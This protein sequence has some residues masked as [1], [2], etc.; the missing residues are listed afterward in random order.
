MGSDTRERVK[1]PLHPSVGQ[2]RPALA[3]ARQR[4][5]FLLDR[6]PITEPNVHR[7][8]RPKRMQLAKP[9]QEGPRLSASRPCALR[10]RGS[11]FFISA[12]TARPRRGGD[13]RKTTLGNHANWWRRIGHQKSLLHVPSGSVLGRIRCELCARRSCASLPDNT[14]SCPVRRA[15]SHFGK[16]TYRKKKTLDKKR[17]DESLT[18]ST[19]RSGGREERY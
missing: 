7:L 13:P 9:R 19:N 11:V 3:R 15:F 6:D 8:H 12:N 18:L 10:N 17:G 4:R 16:H 1:T 2:P 5:E 14:A